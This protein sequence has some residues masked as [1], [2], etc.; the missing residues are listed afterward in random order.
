M[1]ISSVECTKALGLSNFWVIDRTF[2]TLPSLLKQFY[3]IHG[4]VKT[5]RRHILPLVYI[6]LTGKTEKIY[7][8][9]FFN[10]NIM[11]QQK[12]SFFHLGLS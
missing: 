8:E 9:L 3:S 12:M 4:Q 1:A 2:S 7:K 11:L 6:L 5:Y 10:L